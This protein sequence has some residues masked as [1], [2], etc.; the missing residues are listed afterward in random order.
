MPPLREPAIGSAG[1]DRDA[2]ARTIARGGGLIQA[3]G[4]S[5]EDQASA[6]HL[7]AMER[8]GI[9]PATQAVGDLA[10][11]GAAELALSPAGPRVLR[12]QPEGDRGPRPATV[13]GRLK[14]DLATGD[15]PAQKAPRYALDDC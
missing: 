12:T 1:G 6:D 14:A 4:D 7:A 3:G 13:P 2:S 15:S 8:A 5:G 10:G 11:R 9:D